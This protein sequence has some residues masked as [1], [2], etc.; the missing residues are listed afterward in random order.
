LYWCAVLHELSVY[1]FLYQTLVLMLWK[2]F[3]RL[4]VRLL[5]PLKWLMV[6]SRTN[7]QCSSSKFLDSITKEIICTPV[8]MFSV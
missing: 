1:I 4:T 7:L 6:I 5:T 2:I 3:E 8:L